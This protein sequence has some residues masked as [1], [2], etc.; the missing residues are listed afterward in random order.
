VAQQP[1]QPVAACQLI[2]CL[3]SGSRP[4]ASPAPEAISTVR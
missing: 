2:T 4:F 3:H 1:G